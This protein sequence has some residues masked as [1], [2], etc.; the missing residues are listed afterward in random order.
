MKPDN[1]INPT[2]FYPIL[3]YENLYSI[4]KNGEV[5]SNNGKKLKT[6]ITKFG[7]CRCALY[8]NGN[9]KRFAIHRLVAMAFIPNPEN[10]PQVNH[11]DGNKKNNCVEN[12]EWVTAS[13][14]IF[15]AFKNGLRKPT[16]G[17]INGMAK[18]SND[19]V[20][21]IRKTYSEGNISQQKIGEL[22]GVQ[23]SCIQRIV[24]KK[25]WASI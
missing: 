3:G 23:Q 17:I 14:N 21:S 24:S 9:T 20:L 2:E 10:K 15:H 25:R 8:S 5:L 7:Y 4:S 11:K 22:Y 19:D 16:D 13:E 18:L 12:L 6:E 1:K